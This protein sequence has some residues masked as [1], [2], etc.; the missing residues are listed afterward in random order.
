MQIDLSKRADV[1]KRY[2]F[3]CKELKLTDAQIEKL[4]KLVEKIE[5]AR[6]ARGMDFPD[7][8]AQFLDR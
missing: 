5:F 8:L 1:L 7:P 6:A 3:L 4:V 2:E